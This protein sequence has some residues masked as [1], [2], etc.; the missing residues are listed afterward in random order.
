[1]TEPNVKQFVHTV[2]YCFQDF[3]GLEKTKFKGFPGCTKLIFKDIPGYTR[4][5]NMAA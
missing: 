2:K 5:K 1:V 4:F 3:P